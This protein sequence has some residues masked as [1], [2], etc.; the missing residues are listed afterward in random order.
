M[1]RT[2]STPRE[3]ELEAENAKLRADLDSLLAS[4]Q[5]T[6]IR[7][8]EL[9][10]AAKADRIAEMERDLGAVRAERDALRAAPPVA[11]SVA[12]VA[13]EERFVLL[14][15]IQHGQQRLEPGALLPWD[16][17]HPPVGCDGLVEGQQY[18]RRRVLV[19]RAA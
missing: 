15:A 14:T 2:E 17:A 8:L 10:V 19:A 4:P 3:R 7:T 18:A 6:R 5:A 13:D 12:L 9:D 11:E 1:A 16:P